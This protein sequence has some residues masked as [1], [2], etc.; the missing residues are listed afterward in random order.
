MSNLKVSRGNGKT[1]LKRAES[2]VNNARSGTEAFGKSIGN[3]QERKDSTGRVG[4][5]FPNAG[6]P[7]DRYALLFVLDTIKAAAAVG[8]IQMTGHLR[9]EGTSGGVLVYN[10]TDKNDRW[11]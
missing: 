8:Y 5:F 4:I 9:V 7:K 6:L 11:A 3:A 10:V 1:A 2:L